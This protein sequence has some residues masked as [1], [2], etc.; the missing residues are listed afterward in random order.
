ML[1][2]FIVPALKGILRQKAQSD[3]FKKVLATDFQDIM[4]LNFITILLLQ[5]CM[6]QVLFK[7]DEFNEEDRGRVLGSN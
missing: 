1:K 3:L 7:C 4:T 2:I 6:R 5:I